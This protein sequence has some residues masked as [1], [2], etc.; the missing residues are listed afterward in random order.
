MSSK[1]ETRIGRDAATDGATD[2]VAAL[3][4][5]ADSAAT[6]ADSVAADSA[7]TILAASGEASVAESVDAAS[8][9]RAPGAVI[10]QLDVAIG[11]LDAVDFASWSDA[12]LRGHLDEVSLVLCRVDAQ[13]ARLADAVRARGFS[14]TE[15]DLPLAN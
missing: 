9:D 8:D 6:A 5:S 13:L 14:I 15:V 7:A 11:A 12:A 4:D 3:A 10:H 2:S 1:I